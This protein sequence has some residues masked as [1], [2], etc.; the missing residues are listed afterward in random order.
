[1]HFVPLL[2]VSYLLES[3]LISVD[4]KIPCSTFKYKKQTVVEPQCNG[5][6]YIETEF[7]ADDWQTISFLTTKFDDQPCD[8]RSGGGFQ[9]S[10][11]CSAP[12]VWITFARNQSNADH[13][14]TVVEDKGDKKYHRLNLKADSACE[15]KTPLR[16]RVS[17]IAQ[18]VTGKYLAKFSNK[19]TV[20][21]GNLSLS[22]QKP[23]SRGY[24]SW[25]AH[26]VNGSF[27]SFAKP[28]TVGS[29]NVTVAN[30]PDAIGSVALKGVLKQ[31]KLRI[32]LY[33]SCGFE[34]VESS[35]V[36]L[37]AKKHLASKTGDLVQLNEKYF[38]YSRIFVEGSAG[39]AD[40][41]ESHPITL[42]TLHLAN[43]GCAK[44]SLRI[45]MLVEV[46]SLRPK[47][48]V[49]EEG[50]CEDTLHASIKD[51]QIVDS[52]RNLIATDSSV[53][54]CVSD[55]IFLSL[56]GGGKKV[57]FDPTHR[58]VANSVSDSGLQWQSIPKGYTGDVYF[59][60]PSCWLCKVY[61]PSLRDFSISATL[62][63]RYEGWGNEFTM[64]I[65]HPNPD[66]SMS[67]GHNLS[68]R[69]HGLGKITISGDMGDLPEM[70][71][72]FST[73]VVGGKEGCYDSYTSVEHWTPRLFL[74][75]KTGLITYSDL[76]FR[77]PRYRRY[78]NQ[79]FDEI[80]YDLTETDMVFEDAVWQDCIETGKAVTFDIKLFIS[81]Y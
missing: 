43:E 24:I 21:I 39:A 23:F 16:V 8:E 79:N 6:K 2:L 45:L 19:P 66:N 40:V 77:R 32:S 46:W 50:V 4:N 49:N 35:T 37:K 38:K 44:M 53:Q 3:T 74:K 5:S 72:T 15:T 81:N 22:S 62:T 7:I 12:R 36:H 76:D 33:S 60:D 58:E 59:V 51:G 13:L 55:D 9:L 70:Y 20:K 34:Y 31:G 10:G 17:Q 67:F 29:L 78:D 26:Y 42:E 27:M 69:P 52:D 61:P 73:Y 11:G 25:H 63:M 64:L 18:N 14:F 68:N 71:M 1:M 57:V 30:L 75:T 28:K 80:T 65:W 41:I 56:R 48:F 54:G 47:F